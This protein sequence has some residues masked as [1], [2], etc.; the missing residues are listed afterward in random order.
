[1][2]ER[3]INVKFKRRI[4]YYLIRLFR[5][6]SSPHHVALGLSIGFIPSWFPTFALGPFLAVSLARLVKANKISAFIGGVIG[7]A[8]W[9]ILFFMNYI[10][11]SFL[12]ER[13]SSVDELNEVEYIDTQ[14][15]VFLFLSGAVINI[16]IS[17]ILI[18]VIA[19]LLFKKYRLRMLSK[20]K[21]N[22]K[23]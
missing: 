12:F 22:S 5:I 4:K 6:K 16:L 3:I 1:M 21:S 19:Y 13:D 11:G 20:I 15:S 14:S 2:R 7:T 17:S 8:I 10:V 23:V 18:Y 9:P